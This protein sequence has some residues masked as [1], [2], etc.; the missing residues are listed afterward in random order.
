MKVEQR[1]IRLDEGR[2]EIDQIGLRQNRV[3][4]DWIKVDQIGLDEGRIGIPQIRLW[5][6]RHKVDKIM[7]EQRQIR[8]D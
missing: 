7:V 5:Q 1:Q 3:T 2:I 8:L 6:N 4:L